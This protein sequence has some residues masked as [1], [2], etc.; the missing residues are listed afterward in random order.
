MHSNGVAVL[1]EDLARIL[2]CFADSPADIDVKKGQV[3][4]QIRDELIEAN[5]IRQNGQ[6][7]VEEHEQKLPV[8]TWIINRIARV[9][10]LADRILAYVAEPKYFVTPSGRLLDYLSNDPKAEERECRDALSN[11]RDLLGQRPVGTSSVLYLTS[12]AGEGKTTL[13]DKLAREQAERYKQ[14]KVDWLL[15]PISLGGRAFLRFDELVISALVNRFRFQL[16]YYE[17][18]IELVRLGVIVPA[19]DG[20]E[21][22]FVEGSSGEAVSALGNLMNLLNSEGTIL[23]AARK[24][25]FEYQSFRT[26]AR[27][28]D[29]VGDVSVGFAKL[30]IDRWSKGQFI[31]YGHKRGLK[32]AESI[33]KIVVQRFPPEHP[34]LT[35]AVLVR[36]LFDI[37]STVDQINELTEAL[38]T[39]PQDYFYQFVKAIIEREV[40]D[41]W[42]DKQGKEGQSL[43]SI[44]EHLEL[45]AAIAQEMWISC[46]DSLR[47][48]VI[49]LVTDLFCEQKTKSPVFTRQ[50]K[51]RIKTHALLKTV[52]V[53]G[54]GVAFDHDDF[55]EFFI[56]YALGILLV[57]GSR[58]DVRSFLRVAV[59]PQEAVEQVLPMLQ[60]ANLDL[61]T[62]VKDLLG[63]S[64]SESA[65]SFVVENIGALS[66]RVIDGVNGLDIVI[67]NLTFPAQ[68]LRTAS[69]TDVT[70][71]ECYFF[72][73]AITSAIC[74][75]VVF[76]RCIFERLELQQSVALKCTMRDC[77][78]NA[79]VI[80]PSIEDIIYDPIEIAEQLNSHG[81]IVEKVDS[82]K[83]EVRKRIKKDREIISIEKFMRIFLRNTH[84]NDDVIR[85]KLGQDGAH[86]ERDIIP[87]L[88]RHNILAE[89]T[90][91]GGGIQHRYKLMV[92][93]EKIYASI[94]ESGGN[95]PEFLRILKMESR[96]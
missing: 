3:V 40:S 52:S 43:L 60:A 77:V 19:F 30:A 96:T 26:Q 85:L 95:Y 33:Y 72:P 49:D 78:I 1:A 31:D 51:E 75:N 27:L 42:L 7:L 32:N 87:E 44:D 13:I 64:S 94:A 71:E 12:D 16:L 90:Y 38:G 58:E 9:P 88:I 46:V 57:K 35:R 15:L 66:I 59:L 92:A 73:T 23:V 45:L 84:A 47:M 93:M 86:F 14:K 25:Y 22:M 54:G 63:L 50:I 48:D 56:G 74:E 10:L 28:F 81:I 17:G 11:V 76:V 37:A 18:F 79:L 68:S 21:E 70:F 91:R 6:I 34:L 20:F 53:G 55:R 82:R 80:A 89:V 65:T 24:A 67:K 83:K 61:K 29:T 36:R 39:K 41:K 62:L 8:T 2:T 69:I 4:L 5:L